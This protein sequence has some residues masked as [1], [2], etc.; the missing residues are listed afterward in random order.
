MTAAKRRQGDDQRKRELAR[1]HLAAK[2]LGMDTRDKDPRSDY[3]RM[4][5]TVARVHSSSDLDAHGRRAVIAH[6]AA[7]GAKPKRPKRGRSRP[8]NIDSEGRGPL[9]RRIEALLSEAGRP[10]SYADGIARRMFGRERVELCGD[11]ELHR[12]VG[13]MMIDARR[14]DRRTR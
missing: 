2:E 4:L 11:D 12:I 6:L 5:W 7:C 8:H 13:A 14:H 1:I 10:W 9:L 3:R